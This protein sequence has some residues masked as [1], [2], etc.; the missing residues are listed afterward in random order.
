MV[1]TVAFSVAFLVIH[2]GI[3]GQ[4]QPKFGYSRFLRLLFRLLD[5]S[6][7]ER[8]LCNQNGYTLPLLGVLWRVVDSVF[9]LQTLFAE[10]NCSALAS[11][12]L[13]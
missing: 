3:L 4:K 6:G 9:N 8:T 2:R 13:I 5:P 11:Q 7:V 10:E 1:I 12:T